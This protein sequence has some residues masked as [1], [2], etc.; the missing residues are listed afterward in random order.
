MDGGQCGPGEWVS[1]TLCAPGSRALPRLLFITRASNKHRGKIRRPTL[2]GGP[3]KLPTPLNYPT[4]EQAPAD[5]AG[6]PSP[7]EIK[8]LLKRAHDP[9]RKHPRSQHGLGWPRLCTPPGY[10]GNKRYVQTILFQRRATDFPSRLPQNRYSTC[11]SRE[12]LLFQ[13][14]LRRRTRGS[15]GRDIGATPADTSSKLKQNPDPCEIINT[16]LSPPQ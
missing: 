12:R 16:L 5:E 6:P 14:T 1:A 3:L 9:M 2:G 4:G 11:Q 7:G 10:Q 8:W 13:E 15:W